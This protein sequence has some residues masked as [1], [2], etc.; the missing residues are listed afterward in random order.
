MIKGMLSKHQ[1]KIRTMAH[2]AKAGAK[3]AVILKESAPA[4]VIGFAADTMLKFTDSPTSIWSGWSS[5]RDY[6]LITPAIID[7]LVSIPGAK[8]I[9]DGN[10]DVTV[11]GVPIRLISAMTQ[12]RRIAHREGEEDE[13][14]RI[15]RRIMWLKHRGVTEFVGLPGGQ[16]RLRESQMTTPHE[17]PIGVEVADR[18]RRYLEA[19]VSRAILIKGPP[20]TGKT[21]LAAYIASQVGARVLILKPSGL[22]GWSMDVIAMTTRPD[23]VVIDEMDRSQNNR[24]D[25]VAWENLR[26]F[27][28][29]VIATVNDTSKLDY[30]MLRPGR[31]DDVIEV[32]NL[33][34]TIRDSILGDIEDY[35]RE[36]NTLNAAFL[37]EWVTRYQVEG[38]DTRDELER[39]QREIYGEDP[40]GGKEV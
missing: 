38:I 34:D 22:E 5:I 17:T 8:T 30:A 35:D 26:S 36:N 28:P 20:G 21:T 27:C 11:D 7:D 12:D 14:M 4:A 16:V 39:R 29:L 1:A 32:T 15:L 18:V 10:F 33:D 25:M 6:N 2:I 23:V 40:K 24:G 31:F 19:G 13:A 3:A 9:S 37:K